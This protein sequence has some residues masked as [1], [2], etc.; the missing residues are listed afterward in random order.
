MT[1]EE[2][3]DCRVI[4]FQ[5]L[6]GNIILSDLPFLPSAPTAA[7]HLLSS[8]GLNSFPFPSTPVPPMQSLPTAPVLSIPQYLD[9][10]QTTLD[11]YHPTLRSCFESLLTSCT[12]DV[13]PDPPKLK[14]GPKLPEDMRIVEEPGSTPV[15]KKVYLLSPPQITELK[16]QLTKMLE[17]GIIWS[18]NSPYGAPV[19]FPPQ[20]GQR[21][22]TMRRFPST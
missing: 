16:A 22:T 12:A 20:K 14:L 13:F 1:P 15:W 17:A 3:L 6:D 4:Y 8:L 19:L 18:S 21:A 5:E 11:A 7:H 2:Q 10:I 9:R